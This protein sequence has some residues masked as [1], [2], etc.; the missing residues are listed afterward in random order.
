MTRSLNIRIS[1]AHFEH[2]CGLAARRGDGLLIRRS[3]VR[4]QVGE[5][6]HSG[7]SAKQIK[8]LGLRLGAFL[9]SATA[10]RAGRYWK[11]IGALP[12][13]SV[14]AVCLTACGGGSADTPPPPPAKAYALEFFGDSTLVTDYD[15]QLADAPTYASRAT[16]LPISNRAV[17]GSVVV[18]P[19][20]GVPI[21]DLVRASDS[22][23][24]A[25]NFAINDAAKITQDEYRA[26]L[27]DFVT[28]AK[29]SGHVALLIESSPYVDNPTADAARQAYEAIKAQVA[30]AMGATYCRLPGH[31]W[32][33]AEK[34]DGLHPNDAGAKWIGEQQLAPCMRAL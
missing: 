34:P 9:F 26:G 11:D 10:A 19:V 30:A 32:T 23:A 1:R 22:E 28:A 21:L 7:Q 5:P 29:A 16:G 4:A 20:G 6:L 14:L 3:L 13:S 18:Q 2:S 27:Q 15:G 25:A 33:L 24:V 8:H 12:I 17:K 31:D